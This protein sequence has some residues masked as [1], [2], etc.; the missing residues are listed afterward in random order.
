MN[1]EDWGELTNAYYRLLVENADSKIP[2]V[3]YGR[4][5]KG[6]GYH[7]IDY[8][9]HGAAHK[10]IQNYFGRQNRISQKNII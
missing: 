2:K 6:R 10:Q 9:S 7:K 5:I 3:L 1:G 4:N 8:A